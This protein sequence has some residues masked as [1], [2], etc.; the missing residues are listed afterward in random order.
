MK[1]VA[2]HTKKSRLVK[3]SEYDKVQKL[4]LEMVEFCING[5]GIH[6]RGYAIAHMQV[7]DN[8]PMRFFVTLS[9][10]I[11]INPIITRH[12]KTPTMKREGCLSYPEDRPVFVE[13][14][15]K[16]DVEYISIYDGVVEKK[17]DSVRGLEAQIFQ[18]E[19][20]HMDGI[21]IFTKV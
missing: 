2:H 20:D 18:H 7:E 17:T 12:T 8:D 15:T 1:I 3:E 14:F 9:G 21:S 19:I 4:A 5:V 6:E 16:C 13:R 11:V 10:E